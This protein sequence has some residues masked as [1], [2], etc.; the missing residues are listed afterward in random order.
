[1]R[2]RP[3][4]CCAPEILYRDDFL[5]AVNKLPGLLSVPGRGE[6]KRDSVIVRVQQRYPEALVVHRLD[7]ETSGIL[8][9]ARNRSMQ[10]KLNL[11]FAERRIEKTYLALVSGRPAQ[12]KGVIDKPL[13]A[14]WPNRPRQKI[15]H[16]DGKASMTRYELIHYD[17][18]QHTSRLLLWPVTGR[19]HQLRVHLQSI[20][21]PVLGDRLYA[22][23]DTRNRTR[24]LMLHAL[25]LRFTHPETAQ[26]L[27]LVCPADFQSA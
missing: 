11:L 8:L 3:P 9:M 25:S 16:A 19:S 20:G 5:L 1:M 27:H 6:D 26:P 21:H 4:P 15:D 2:Y 24:R 14:D 10:R 12:D 13:A 23:T 18:E 7:M 22:D 17:R